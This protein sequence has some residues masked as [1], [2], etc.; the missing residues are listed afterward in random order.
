MGS[1]DNFHPWG[2]ISG[3]LIGEDM[4]VSVLVMFYFLTWVMVFMD[5]IIP[6]T[7]C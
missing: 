7:V 6:S 3:V 2:L 4:G 1:Q 5:V